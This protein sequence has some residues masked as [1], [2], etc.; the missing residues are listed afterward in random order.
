M[1]NAMH[2]LHSFTVRALAVSLSTLAVLQGAAGAQTIEYYH[3]DAL[4]SV[5]A[6]TDQSGAVIERHDYLP[7][8]EE[9]GPPGGA[10]PRQF[11]SKER[12]AETGLDYFGARYYS[13]KRARFT[14]I[15][16]FYSWQENLVD[17]QRWNRYAYVRNNPLR[18][19]DPDGRN[20][21]LVLWAAYEVG[22]SVYD[23]YTTYSTVTNPSASTADKVFTTG[24]FIAG[25]LPGVP[26]GAPG[27]GKSARGA[28]IA[29]E[30]GISVTFHSVQQKINRGIRSA[31]ELDAI[32]N[33][34]QVKPVRLDEHGRPS[35]RSIGSRAE[36]VRNPDTG[37]I[38]TVNPTSTR[39][40]QKLSNSDD[41]TK[42]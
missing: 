12:D 1:R 41:K 29:T 17:P 31:D 21:L 24:L 7:F 22:S 40:A 32:K 38:V 20:P 11:T 13:G 28:L 26:G 23:A 6:V 15:D 25:M 5:R 10:Q 36:V 33:P 14:T 4:G 2:T 42:P 27:V 9:I 30:S 8:G 37:Q 34:L 16:P 19:T 35:Q 18:F 39:K 3:L